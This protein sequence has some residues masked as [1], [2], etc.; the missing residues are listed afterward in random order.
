[1][2][3]VIVMNTIQ[4]STKLTPA[5]VKSLRKIS[6]QTHI[7]QAVLI[8]QAVDIL[9]EELRKKTVSLDFLNLVKKKV[10]EDK[11]LLKRLASS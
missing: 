10:K 11:A 7:P 2:V 9:I 4:Y 6:E 3:E 8:R 5:Q 1:M